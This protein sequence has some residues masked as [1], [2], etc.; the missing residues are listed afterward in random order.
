M[1]RALDSLL[2]LMSGPARLFLKPYQL[3]PSPWVRCTWARV[4]SLLVSDAISTC[5]FGSGL[6]KA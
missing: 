6:V 5:L 2:G 3:P 1:D 4:V